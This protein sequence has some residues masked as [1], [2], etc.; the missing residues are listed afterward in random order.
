[1]L[2]L[3]VTLSLYIVKT[4]LYRKTFFLNVLS[5]FSYL[6]LCVSLS[7]SLSFPD[8][9]RRCPLS[10]DVWYVGGHAEIAWMWLFI[11]NRLTAGWWRWWWWLENHGKV[12][13]R[14]VRQLFYITQ[15]AEHFTDTTEEKVGEKLKFPSKQHLITFWKWEIK[16][17]NKTW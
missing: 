13:T 1:M 14:W 12:G 6:S 15:P 2:G 3:L 10:G 9:P 8:E 5:L 4:Y 17:T 16:I 7:S 11:D